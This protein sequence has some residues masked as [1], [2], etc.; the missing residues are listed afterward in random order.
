MNFENLPF[1]H[2]WTVQK[3][4]MNTIFKCVEGLGYSAAAYQA[5]KK[6]LERTYGG[7]FLYNKK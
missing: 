2:V 6:R 1:I 3:A 4:Q 5:A 7:H